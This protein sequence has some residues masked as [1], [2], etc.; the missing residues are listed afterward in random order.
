MSPGAPLLPLHRPVLGAAE[1]AAVAEVLAS[2]HLVQGPR[3]AA[4]EAAVAERLGMA[5]A[6]ACSSGTAALHLSLRSLGVGAG[7][8]VLVPAFGFPATANAVELCGARAVP[9]DVD[10]DTFALTA[11]SLERAATERT[12]GV[13]PV[14]PFGI[15][16]DMQALEGWA[17]ARG[18]WMLEDAACALGTAQ[19]EGRW[20]SGRHPVCLSFHPRKTITT[21]EGGMVL[22]GDAALAR[23]ARRLCNHGMAAPGEPEAGS[24][25]RFVEAGF[26]YRMTDIAAAIGLCQLQRLDGIVA[27]RQR[28]VSWYRAALAATSGVRVPAGYALPEL[29][30]QSFVVLLDEDRDRDAVIRSLGARGIQTTI[31]GYDLAEQPYYAGR[32]DLDQEGLSGARRAG[33]SSLT[34]PVGGE[35]SAAD[36][37]RVVTALAE[38]VER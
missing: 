17:G 1:A 24:W 28:V 32:Y 29:S 33:R 2:G 12:V 4:F 7:D 9:A 26:N 8:D 15:P 31:G 37:E 21:G 14:H 38:E 34:L 22:T 6:V 27:G 16:A 36:V 23:R 13:I 5:H 19:P 25:Q 20:A 35:M 18:V 10:L 3:V 11:G 30:C